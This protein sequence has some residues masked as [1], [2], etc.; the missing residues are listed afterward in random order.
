M[1]RD[2]IVGYAAS[3]VLTSPLIALGAIALLFAL[4][5]LVPG[6]PATTLL[7]P[8]A[9]PEAIAA[10]RD[11]MGLDQPVLVRLL[12]FLW[13]VVHGDLGTDVI[14]GRSVASMVGDALPATLVLT[15]ASLGLAAALGIPLGCYA[16]T[17]PGGFLDRVSAIVSVSIIAV[18]SYV[19]AIFLLLVFTLWLGWLPALGTGEGGDWLDA[20][21]RLILPTI[22]LAAGWVGYLARL[23]RASLIEVLGEA[24]IRTMRAF[25]LSERLI[26]YKYALKA[27]LSPVLAVLG[28]GIGKLLGGA[29]F[30][31]IVFAR[32]GIGKL[33]YEA[34]GV[35]NYPVVQ[36]T[37]LVVVLLFVLAN[38]AVDL[39][40]AWMDPRVRA[41]LAASGRPTAP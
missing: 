19:V 8:R 20:A 1:R 5:L 25:G 3:R 26:V 16:A 11:R 9:T 13:Q 36:G 15:L 35:R 18:P 27:A 6:D 29:V 39:L 37:V 38:L 4:T 31:E 10:L 24:H 17:H 30:I 33:L 12:R 22:A 28:L 2:G 7:G 23:T 41:A 34:I 40:H 21:R 14:S 32:P